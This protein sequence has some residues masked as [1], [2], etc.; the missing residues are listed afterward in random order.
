MNSNKLKYFLITLFLLPLSYGAQIVQQT[1]NA[2]AEEGASGV[3]VF[4]LIIFVIGMLILGLIGGLLF[5]L[6][7]IYKAISDHNR[8]KEDFI[9]KIYEQDKSQC[10]VNANPLMKKRNWKRLWLFFK[11]KPVYMRN[12]NGFD[13]LGLYDGECYKKEGYFCLSLFHKI[14]IFKTYDNMIIIP[15][16]IKDELVS[17]INVEGSEVYVL[18]CEGI[19]QLGN[20]DYYFQPLI[21]DKTR[22][23]FIDYNDDLHKNYFE[24]GIYRDII[25]E[26]LQSYRE[27]VIKSLDANPKVQYERRK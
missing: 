11:R 6:L 27:N 7:K 14:G 8:S 26:N 2:V 15:I 19:D 18:D 17:K 13:V 1:P 25:K 10:K 4:I 21:W 20:T 5:I 3:A 12:K 24:K 16:K 9:F 23:E 22:K